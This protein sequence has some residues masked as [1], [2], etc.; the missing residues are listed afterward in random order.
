ML[1]KRIYTCQEKL[2]I[3][4]CHL[5][6]FFNSVLTPTHLLCCSF[7]LFDDIPLKKLQKSEDIVINVDEEEPQPSTVA[8][9]AVELPEG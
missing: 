2:P 8:E 3:W 6:G 4:I 9:Q 1:F 7:N 5:F